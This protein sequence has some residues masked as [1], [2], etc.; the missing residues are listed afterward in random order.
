[1]PQAFS[2]IICNIVGGGIVA[3]LISAYHWTIGK[4]KCH[5]FRQVFGDDRDDLCIVYPSCEVP[6]GITFNKPPSRVPRRNITT[7][8]LTTVN[9]NA[10]TRSVSHMA[11]V[12]GNSS[13]SLPRISSDIEMDQ[14]M[15]VSF[16]SVGGL[17]NYKSLDILENTSNVFLQ[18]DH[19]CI[20]SKTS[21]KCIVKI[22]GTTDF[23][24]ILK[25]HP[26]NNPKRTWLC[27]AGIGEWGTSG[28]SWW[29]SRHW[30]TIQ[31][32]AKDKPFA[33]ITK[34]RYGSDDST[35]LV[36]LFLSKEDIEDI[37]KKAFS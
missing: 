21:E 11:Y 31:K 5:A 4:L 2:N 13:S 7:V 26:S 14:Y 35:S 9:S 12:F 30:K 8:N 15:D 36:H 22:Q 33:C 6:N 34:T 3:M 18:F 19:D 10:N 20:Q 23:G 32:R 37:V 29:L 1:M 28:A 17:N 25:I 16:I 27:V 24:L